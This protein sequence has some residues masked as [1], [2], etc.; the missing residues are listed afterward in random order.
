M[1]TKRGNGSG[2]RSGRS[3]RGFPFD[4]VQGNDGLEGRLRKARGAEIR[5]GPDG[6]ARAL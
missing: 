3:E 1:K 5:L 4:F 2:K 6:G